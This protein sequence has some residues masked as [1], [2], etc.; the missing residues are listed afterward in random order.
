MIE[1]FCANFIAAL[2]DAHRAKYDIPSHFVP[3]AFSR[4]GIVAWGSK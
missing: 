4:I 1:A 3:I 2:I